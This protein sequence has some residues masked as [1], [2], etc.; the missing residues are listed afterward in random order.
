MQ[1]A[2]TEGPQGSGITVQEV[3]LMLAFAIPM[4]G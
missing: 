4:D 2:F 1:S 3:V